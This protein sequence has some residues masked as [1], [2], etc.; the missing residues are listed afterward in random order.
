MLGKIVSG[1]GARRLAA[2]V[3]G[4][5]SAA[6]GTL[7]GL[8]RA[9]GAIASAT[10]G[11]ADASKQ[12]TQEAPTNVIYVNFGMAGSAGKQKV[13]G[14]GTL[15]ARSN[16]A[17]P[18][19]SEK[20]PAEALLNTVVK[21][22]ESIDKSLKN[23]LEFEKRLYEQ[24]VR[25]EREAI[26]ENKPP[27]SFSDIKDKFSNLKSNVSEGTRLSGKLAKYALGLGALAAV[28][29]SSLDQAQLDALKQNVGEFK[30]SFGWLGEIGAAVGAGGL[31]GFLFGG[32]GVVGRLKGGLVGMVTSHVISRLYP[33]LFGGESGTIDPETGEVIPGT[34][35]VRESRSMSALEMGMSLGAGAFAARYGIKKF[36][37]VRA[38]GARMAALRNAA[39]SGT[40]SQAM[41][42][43]R[44]GNSWL[45]SR[46]GR[47]F[48]ALVAKKL[49][50]KLFS[51]IAKTL[52]RIAAM[53][54]LGATVVGAIPAIIG[55]IATVGFLLFDLYDIATAIWDAWN[56]SKEED[57]TAQAIPTTATP[58]ATPAGGSN[59]T[60]F[61]PSTS[62]QNKTITGVVEGGRGYTTVTYADG[63]I[64]RRTGTLPAR[65]N[66]P[67][68]IM[69]GDIAKSYGAVGSSPSTN[70]PPVAVFPTP[71]AGF[72]AMDGLL[73]SKYSNGP[74]GQTIEAW[75]TDPSHPAKV[76]GTAGVDPNKRY[77]DFTQDEKTRFQQAI[78]KIEGYY[79]A[80]SGPTV[81]SAGGGFESGVGAMTSAGLRQVGE[82]LGTLGSAVIKP[83]IARTFEASPSNAPAQIS[84]ESMKLQT[85]LTLGLEREKT[86]DLASTPNMPSVNPGIPAPIRSISSMD[87]NYN[88]VDVL[89]Q[90]L[91]HFKKAA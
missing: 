9:A 52:G 75:A 4:A 65:T 23:Q 13:S 79:A 82:L 5:A 15:P 86:K 29:A 22:L 30:K 45:A 91:G 39:R 12:K 72:A 2:A 32:R 69:Y 50:R 42:S 37:Q 1:L 16:V 54:L 43:I 73:T 88:N 66:N 87:P 48:I 20:M 76:I 36:R 49:G 56:E 74:I 85:N 10:Q 77:T 46:R 6:Y 59:A 57:T 18:Q 84:S 70:G 21:Y 25:D 68:N 31:L 44:K 34:E 63:T 14:G 64:E 26:V 78:A 33:S 51:K 90:Y 47:K 58:D 83:G 19:V 35:P 8:S 81:F 61:T 28:V 7:S 17:K 27:F 53:L 71:E 80:G 60:S 89:S 11:A 62:G 55:I 40:A 41:A 3:G 38:A 67:G 24:Q